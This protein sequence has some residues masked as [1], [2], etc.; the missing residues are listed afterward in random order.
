MDNG[1]GCDDD[2]EQGRGADDAEDVVLDL[3]HANV[4]REAERAHDED[5]VDGA[6]EKGR[7]G[8][9]EDED[10][11]PRAFR[12]LRR[13]LREVERVLEVSRVLLAPERR[14]RRRPS[15]RLGAES[16]ADDP[17]A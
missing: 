13:T 11:E 6:D 2:G 5:E 8:V 10:L 16:L 4:R 17:R 12:L 9:L 7:E 14:P 15:G 3:L 1:E